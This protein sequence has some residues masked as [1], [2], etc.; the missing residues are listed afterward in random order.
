MA[1]FFTSSTLN[2]I[3]GD[4]F[5]ILAEM[6][7]STSLVHPGPLALGELGKVLNINKVY[8]GCVLCFLKH[9]HVIHLEA[10]T[11]VRSVNRTGVITLA[12]EVRKEEH[13]R[14]NDFSKFTQPINH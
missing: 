12:L 5:I 9:C 1:S 8:L 14:L 6:E 7:R 3:G 4:E 10:H 2:W 11:T 13:K